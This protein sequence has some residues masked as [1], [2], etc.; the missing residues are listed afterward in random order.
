MTSTYKQRQQQHRLA[1][2]YLGKPSATGGKFWKAILNG[3][4]LTLE[5][6]SDNGHYMG[7]KQLKFRSVYDATKAYTKRFTAKINEG[8]DYHYIQSKM[9]KH[10]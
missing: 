8:Y 10:V 4:T 6:G 5:W 1:S 3:R 7:T 9:Y 2:V